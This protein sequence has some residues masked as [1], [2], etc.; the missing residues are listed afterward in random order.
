MVES[1]PNQF[2]SGEYWEM[3]MVYFLLENDLEGARHLWRRIRDEVKKSSVDL[4]QIWEIGISLLQHDVNAAYEIIKSTAWRP[5]SV[6]FIGM[7]REHIK[8]NQLRTI[9][10]GYSS[11]A[12]A[13]VAMRLDMS[14]EEASSTCAS[15][16]WAVDAGGIV[17]ISPTAPMLQ[18]PAIGRQDA[19]NKGGGG[20]A[21]LS[22]QTL[23]QNLSEYIGHFESKN[24]R[25][26]LKSEGTGGGGGGAGI[27][28][29]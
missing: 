8:T 12:I 26:D 7:L 18:L 19:G 25:V 20:D 29:V 14:V 28:K 22:H 24:L 15:L 4:C 9:S 27:M 13:K 6:H 5:E 23:M 11:L 2:L 10:V 21:L 3:Y 17:S 16:Q 1:I